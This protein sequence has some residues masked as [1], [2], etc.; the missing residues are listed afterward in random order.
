M[1]YQKITK[2]KSINVFIKILLVG[3]VGIPLIICSLVVRVSSLFLSI[4]LI[5]LNSIEELFL[6]DFSSFN[7][8]FKNIKKEVFRNFN[9]LKFW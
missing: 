5:I 2:N 8:I 4:F 6:L 3:I 7:F 1:L 9:G